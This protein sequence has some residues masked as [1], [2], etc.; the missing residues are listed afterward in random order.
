MQVR[1]VRVLVY[2]SA[3]WRPLERQCSF[4]IP[5]A[6]SPCGALADRWVRSATLWHICLIPLPYAHAGQ[7]PKYLAAAM[8]GNKTCWALNGQQFQPE[9]KGLRG[10]LRTY[11]CVTCHSAEPCRVLSPSEPQ[12]PLEPSLCS[13]TCCRSQPGH[14]EAAH[15]KTR[16]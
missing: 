13:A 11:R 3:A 6:H 4:T 16:L 7:V 10:L 2:L 14:N 1:M 5:C 12:Q 15:V 8:Q 9:V